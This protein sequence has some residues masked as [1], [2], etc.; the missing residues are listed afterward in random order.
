MTSI[1]NRFLPNFKSKMDTLSLA[2]SPN[3]SFESSNNS[4]GT[5]SYS[6]LTDNND[7]MNNDIN[8]GMNN[9]MNDGMNDRMNDEMSGNNSDGIV[10]SPDVEQSDSLT[11]YLDNVT[12]NS[13]NSEMLKQT[14]LRELPSETDMRNMCD[15]IKT[16]TMSQQGWINCGKP[17][18]FTVCSENVL[19]EINSTAYYLRTITASLLQIQQQGEVEYSVSFQF[20]NP[21]IVTGLWNNDYSNLILQINQ[22]ENEIDSTSIPNGRLIMGFGPSASGKTY[23]AK[24]IIYLMTMVDGSFPKY[25]L[26]ID[27]GIYR[28]E[29]LT[30]QTILDCIHVN[31]SQVKGFNNLVSTNAFTSSIFDSNIVKAKINGYLKYLKEQKNIKMNLYV[32]DTLSVCMPSCNS[33][34]G[35]YI[36][37]TGDNNWI[38]T[39]IWQHMYGGMQ[40][41]YGTKYG[42]RFQ[43]KGCT[44]SG[45]EREI[46]EGKKYSN[47][48]WNSS[49]KNGR[50]SMMKAPNYR[51]FIHNSGSHE[52]WS[53]VKDYSRVPVSEDVIFYLEKINWRYIDHTGVN[54][55]SFSLLGGKAK[56]H[57]QKCKKINRKFSK[58]YKNLNHKFTKKHKSLN[59]KTNKGTNKKTNKGTNKKTNQK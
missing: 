15:A 5:G 46:K 22:G 49:Y 51:F 54:R 35:K 33:I 24:Q 56:Y 13:N 8:N 21:N 20:V 58:K 50:L 42:E 57:T 36:Y 45:Q 29:C 25:F 47:S 34:Y 11:T 30:Y 48:A 23:C 12:I 28:E 19:K 44:E 31:N 39:L 18:C 43:C 26:S 7:M 37:L 38:G 14:L 10:T 40:C 27:G 53:I 41:S 1:I 55:S 2:S 16:T 9:E 3:T 6:D 17:T 32:P 4:F 52:N 59:K